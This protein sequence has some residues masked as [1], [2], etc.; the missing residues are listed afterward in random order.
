MPSGARS[1]FS[2][3]TATSSAAA[4]CSTRQTSTPRSRASTSCNR[5]AAAGKR[6]EPNARAPHGVRSPPHD[7]NA[8]S[9]ILADDIAIDD[10]RR[11]VNAGIMHGRDADIA[12]MRG[13]IDVGITNISSTLIATRGDRLDLCRTCISG[14]DRPEA[15]QIEFFT[16]SRSTPTSGSWHGSLFDLDDVDAAFEELDARYLAGEA[17]AHAH[18]WSVMAQNYAALNRSRATPGDAGLGQHRPPA[19]TTFRAR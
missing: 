8:L 15:F 9:E 2:H 1:P 4:S 18:T 3:S 17:A 16:S 12:D 6:G 14:Q 11:V 10:R 7:W 13:V 5:D 19:G